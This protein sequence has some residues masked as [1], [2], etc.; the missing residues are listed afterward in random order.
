MDG[1]RSYSMA[2]LAAGSGFDRR[3]IVYY[4]Q[5]GLLPKAGRRGPRTR[6]PAH[7]LH[8]LLFIKGVRDLQ[9]RGELLTATLADMGRVLAALPDETLASLVAAG[10]VA[11]D[12]QPLFAAPVP[13]PQESPVP[14]EAPSPGLATASPP[15]PVTV[16]ITAAAPAPAPVPLGDR[17]SYGLADAG[18]RLRQP[19]PPRDAPKSPI[20]DPGDTHPQ[21]PA[22]PAAIPLAPAAGPGLGSGTSPPT[23]L[24]ADVDGNL[25]ELLRQLEVQLTAERR[26]VAPGASEQ[27]TEFPITSRVYLSIRGLGVEDAPVAESL[28]RVL[29]RA[30]RDR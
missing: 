19:L 5:A 22:L 29:K 18:I 8:R 28:A 9:S 11:R 27:W 4:I 26:R 24:S 14:P 30:L 21:L 3:T 20:H 15:A 10:V 1:D 2:E 12:I 16:P 7:C 17:R 13:P 6:Y 23:T 25:G